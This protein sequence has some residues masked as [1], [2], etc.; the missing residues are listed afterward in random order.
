[1]ASIGLFSEF[2]VSRMR[3][4]VDAMYGRN[5]LELAK[6]S[7]VAIAVLNSRATLRRLQATRLVGDVKAFAPGIRADLDAADREWTSYYIGRLPDDRARALAL[8]LGALI[9][10]NRKYA[11]EALAAFTEGHFNSGANAVNRGADVAAALTGVLRDNMT[12]SLQEAKGASDEITLT[13]NRIQEISFAL[14]SAALLLAAVV[15]GAL[16]RS[17][18]SSLN[19][20]VSFANDIASGELDNRFAVDS[21]D[22]IGRLFLAMK[23]M[24]RRLRQMIYY[25]PLTSTPNRILFN[26]RLSE[27]IAESSHGALVG[28]MMIDIDRFKGINDTLGHAAGDELLRE[29]AGRLTACVGPS[30]TVARL[31]GD[32]FAVLLPRIEDRSQAERI[33]TAIIEK[34]DECFQVSG[35]EVFVSCSI[36]IALYPPDGVNPGDLMKFADSAMYLA[37]RSGRRGFRFYNKELTATAARNLTIESDLRRGIERDEFELHYQ[38]K[39]SL[40]SGEIVGSE[41][42]LRWC[43]PGVGL[44]APSVFIPVAEEVGLIE[45]L[46]E[47][48]LREA[49]RTAAEWNADGAVPHKIAANL[50]ARQFQFGDIVR[51]IDAILRET[52]CRPEWIELEITESLLLAENSAI[53]SVLS[54]FKERGLSIAIDD[55][56]T[57]YASLSYLAH[58]P[59]DTLKID[60]SFVQK[61]TI[62]GRYA[63]LV[64]AI[65]SIGQCLG[66]QVVAEGVETV[67]QA[68]FLAASGCEIGQGFLYGRPLRKAAIGSLPRYVAPTQSS[69][70]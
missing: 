31:G 13:A 26:Q 44:I 61:V 11:N 21:R 43:R 29:A 63:E 49:C 58:F 6:L 51:S 66:L 64:K 57:G 56:G 23:K 33:A 3:S 68:S 52:G 10:E 46:G 30:G 41:A 19:R 55:F 2:S 40:K 14:V 70:V 62:D 36:G 53:S 38:P 39:V 69:A 24:E 67:E 37:K 45:E 35:K 8:H 34:F 17:I 47:W 42:L 9:A 65:V 18:L 15:S 54:S 12:L 27:A 1:M 20:A 32:E 25:D 16:L 28:V 22:E 59:I 50:S 48:V 5:T 60:K 7:N 4:D